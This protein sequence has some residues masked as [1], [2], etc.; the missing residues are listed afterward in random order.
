MDTCQTSSSPARAG[1]PQEG[2]D[3]QRGTLLFLSG[4]P[5]S[6][7]TSKAGH[8][9]THHRRVSNAFFGLRRMRHGDRTAFDQ[10]SDDGM[11]ACRA[12]A[13]VRSATALTLGAA[14]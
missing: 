6:S 9:P 14:T 1:D 3:N 5:T 4:I 11:A 10:R 2:C 13:G 8:N 12:F 7:W